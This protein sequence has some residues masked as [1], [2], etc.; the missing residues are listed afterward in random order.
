MGDSNNP[1]LGLINLLEW[2]TELRETLYLLDYW[3]M[4]KGHNVGTG[5][6]KRS[7]HRPRYEQRAQSLHALSGCTTLSES[8]PA[9][10]PEAL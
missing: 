5:E 3:F 2:V 6:W 7:I 10:N 9:L 1:L 8:P 4:I